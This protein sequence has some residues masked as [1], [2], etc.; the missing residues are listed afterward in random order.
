M[1]VILRHRPQ[2]RMNNSA[3]RK[4]YLLIAGL[5]TICHGFALSHVA[6]IDDGVDG[7]INFSFLVTASLVLLVVSFVFI[8]SAV[9]KPIDKIC[10]FVF[11]FAAISLLLVNLYPEQAHVLNHFPLGMQIHILTSILAFSVLSI[12]AAQS[13]LVAIQERQ[14]RSHQPNRLMSSL[15]PLQVM[16]HLLFEM[17]GAGFLL[18]TVALVAGLIFVHD[19]FAQHLVH[20]TVLSISA[21][22][23]FGS[24][25]FGKLYYGWRGRIA[26]RWTLIGF[27]TLVLAYFGSKM[28]LEIILQRT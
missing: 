27:I 7:G 5:A 21:W 4:H 15:P 14:L 25:L 8:L 3:A 17:I 20:K 1:L 11:P 23:V 9:S 6:F 18:L 22:L 28:V 16:E 24:L 12:A 13:I 10:L 19:L 2:A 26:I